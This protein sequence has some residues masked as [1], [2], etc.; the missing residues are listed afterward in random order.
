MCFLCVY[1]ISLANFMSF[2][3]LAN[4]ICCLNLLHL[5][6]FLIVC[7]FIKFLLLEALTE[8]LSLFLSV[9]PIQSCILSEKEQILRA[10]KTFFL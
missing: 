6:G 7:N 1:F 9:D 10:F 8:S 4:G 5:V 3:T 2:P